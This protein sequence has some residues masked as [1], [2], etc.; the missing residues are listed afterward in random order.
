MCTCRARPTEHVI[1]FQDILILGA[2]FCYHEA[3]YTMLNIL[4]HL[5]NEKKVPIFL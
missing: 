1:V 3:C 4:D 2:V 5:E